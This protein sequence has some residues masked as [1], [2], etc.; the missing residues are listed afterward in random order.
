[1]KGNLTALLITSTIILI[2]VLIGFLAGR[3]KKSRSSV[4]E[5]SVG[6]R[7]L[8]SLFVWFLVGADIYTAYTF[9]G[10]TSSAY[11]G[12]SIAFF[13]TPY[14]VLAYPIAYF[15]LPRLWKVANHHKFMTLSDYIR[16]R[17]DSKLMSV[18]VALS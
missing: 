5:W 16:G 8:G 7:R 10:L 14:V 3:N 13:A 9:L 15:F 1:M 12:G 17:F 2:V 6:G 11:S 4:E 18:L